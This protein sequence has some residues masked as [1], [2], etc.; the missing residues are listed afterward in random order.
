MVHVVIDRYFSLF[1]KGFEDF[2][3]PEAITDSP[4]KSGLCIIRGGSINDHK[5][6]EYIALL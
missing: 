5:N 1:L 4:F 2:S 6:F 3:E